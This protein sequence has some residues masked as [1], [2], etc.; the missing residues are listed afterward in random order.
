MTIP[1]R[2][3]SLHRLL[4][5]VLLAL[6][7]PT[8]VFASTFS[9]RQALTRQS[10]SSSSGTVGLERRAS[11]PA[12]R[13]LNASVLRPYLVP[14]KKSAP[15]RRFARSSSSAPARTGE[16][17]F[18]QEML[19]LVNQE[20]F[21]VGLTA[22]TMNLVLQNSAQAYAEDMV[23]RKFFSHTDPQGKG[24]LDRI[25]ASGYLMPPC[26]CVWRYRT[27]ENLGRGQTTPT[28]VVRDWMKSKLHREN[29]LS[30]QFKEIGIGK[31]GDIWVQHFGLVEAQ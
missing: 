13:L 15:V 16:D 11:A 8:G 6:W 23:K 18:R 25:R 7:F 1:K 21:A 29:I 26:D 17:A 5:I 19:T 31:A 12:R 9:V 24:S 4:G 2:S 20:R 10:A 28:Q 3:H 30:P 27:G 22:L 14:P